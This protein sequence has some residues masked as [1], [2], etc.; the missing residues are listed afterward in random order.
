MERLRFQRLT[1]VFIAASLAACSG[2]AA[3]PQVTTQSGSTQSTQSS[4]QSVTQAV[5]ILSS[6]KMKIRLVAP[7]QALM[8]RTGV[9]LNLA[10]AQCKHE[11]VPERVDDDGL[12]MNP[13]AFSPPHSATIPF[14]VSTFINPCMDRH[15]DGIHTMT[16]VGAT[17]TP[18]PPPSIAGNG[19][20]VIALDENS[21]GTLAVVDIAGPA[22]IDP[23]GTMHFSKTW[24]PMSASD[25]YAFYLATVR[26]HHEGHDEDGGDD[27]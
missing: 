15:E 3:N 5:S 13:K 11:S 14:T 27:D 12:P 10:D 20:Y 19:Y 2:N 24:V 18:P 4:T 26:A 6:H 17:P 16:V 22:T 1:L 7:M 21:N 23:D 8:T 25:T 9:Q